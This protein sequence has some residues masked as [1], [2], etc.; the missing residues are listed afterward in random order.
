MTQMTTGPNHPHRM[1]QNSLYDDRRGKVSL[2]VLA[3]GLGRLG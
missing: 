1:T 3:L 2:F